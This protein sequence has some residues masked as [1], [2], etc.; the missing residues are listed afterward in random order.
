MDCAREVR[1]SEYGD[2]L[3]HWMDRTPSA[4]TAGKAAVKK[5]TAKT[6]KKSVIKKKPKRQPRR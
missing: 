6:L 4:A 1:C 5:S 2:A 3:L